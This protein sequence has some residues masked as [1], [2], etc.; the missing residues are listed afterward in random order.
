MIAI[1]ISRTHRE[2]PTV[3]AALAAGGVALMLA[4]SL[5]RCRACRPRPG[6]DPAGTRSAGGG[7][8][9]GPQRQRLDPLD[10]EGVRRGA[11]QA[12]TADGHQ[13]YDERAGHVIQ[14]TDGE[15]AADAGDV[16]G[17]VLDAADRGD[18]AL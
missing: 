10:D 15:R 2:R 6:R 17:E 1:G 7:R 12:E 8:L 5:I 14:R 9:R 16:R 13:R 11:D 18:L 4:P 3:E